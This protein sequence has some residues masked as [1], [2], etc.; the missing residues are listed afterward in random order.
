[1]TQQNVAIRLQKAQELFQNGEYK[2]AMRY[3]GEIYNENSNIQEAKIGVFLCDMAV[4]SADEAQALFDYYYLIKDNQEDAAEVISE[5]IETLDITKNSIADLISTRVGK[6]E[7]VD[8]ISYSDFMQI[9]KERG[10]FRHA[11]EDIMFSTRIYLTSKVELI[12][13]ITQLH[14]GGFEK[15][16]LQYLDDTSEIFD[17]DQ[18]VMSLYSLFEEHK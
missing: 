11:F 16:A 2:D 13:F 3:Y 5:I 7:D 8:G 6:I 4:D 10:D 18:D 1:M 17:Y 9:V 15:M 14:S 12:D